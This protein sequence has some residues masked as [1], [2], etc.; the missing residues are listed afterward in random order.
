MSGQRRPNGET[1]DQQ[2]FYKYE[3]ILETDEIR[4]LTSIKVN[5]GASLVQISKL[6]ASVKT[7]TMTPYRTHGQTKMATLQSVAA[8]EFGPRGCFSQPRGA[9]TPSC[10]RCA[11]TPD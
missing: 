3:P 9:A 10:D 11:S 6:F 4:L 2:G 8:S 1:V 5:R 7:T